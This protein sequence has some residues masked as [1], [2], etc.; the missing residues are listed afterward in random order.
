MTAEGG[1]VTFTI[2]VPGESGLT[3]S[4]LSGSLSSG[5]STTINISA[6][7]SGTAVTLTVDPGDA[8]VTVEFPA[9]N[10]QL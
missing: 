9:P 1:A 6:P 4:P 7:S 2:T 3:V 5:Q 10:L 8:P